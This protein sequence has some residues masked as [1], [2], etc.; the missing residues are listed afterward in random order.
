M[1]KG[2]TFSVKLLLS[3]L[4]T[5]VLLEAGLHLFPMVIPLPLLIY[6]NTAVRA[7]IAHR[8]NLSNKWDVIYLERDDGGPELWIYRPGA[9][10]RWPV[11]DTGAVE[12]RQMDE[13]GFC[14][15]P[16]H[17]YNLSQIDI[18]A[19]GDSFTTCYAVNP[20]D[21]WSSQLGR[22]TGLST[23]N[24][25][26]IGLGTHGEIQILKQ[27]G[28]QKSPRIVILNVYEGNDLRDAM[29]YYQYRQSQEQPETQSPDLNQKLTDTGLLGRYSYVFNLAF[30]FINYS[31]EKFSNLPSSDTSDESP[32][33]ASTNGVDF[34]Y[35]LVF[36]E[37]VIP[38]NANNEDRDEV[39]QARSVQQRT[40][41]G[42]ALV[43]QVIGEPLTVFVQ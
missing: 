29:R 12:I 43:K 28:L 9:M 39:Y 13:M 37:T 18:I 35:D 5:L 23:Y 42:E 16:E 14:N 15:P 34:R 19:L 33:S 31:Q 1:K 7:E 2:L 11:K 36:D 10:V 40:P 17:S 8:L 21:T 24:L 26:R 25:G 38:F 22:L 41:A 6:F 30:A 20:S 32:D 3:V 27:F 4:F